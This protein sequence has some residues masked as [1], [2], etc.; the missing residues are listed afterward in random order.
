MS[1]TLRDL[2]LDAARDEP[3]HLHEI[4]AIVL[5]TRPEATEHGI[6]ARIYELLRGPAPRMMRVDES[7]YVAVDGPAWMVMLVGDAWTKLRELPNECANLLLTDAPYRMGTEKHVNTG[8]T[9]PHAR[10]QGRTYQTRDLDAAWF[11]EAFRVIK[12]NHAWRKMNGGTKTSGG[13]LILFAPA[14]TETTWPHLRALIDLAESCGFAYQGRVTWVHDRGMGYKVGGIQA[15]PILVFNKGRRDGL[16]HDTKFTNVITAK[17]KRN[18][19]KPGA[20]RHEAE[21]PPEVFHRL[22]EATTRPGDT[23]LDPF[24]GAASWARAT[25][26]SGRN[27]IL[28]D[29]DPR[30][31]AAIATAGGAA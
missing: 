26:E 10:M 9:R 13:A 16:L 17:R 8:T 1:A 30:W 18:P 25:L 14:E 11:R 23:V 28:I 29:L 2:V 19:C 24:A 31:P 4:L 6:R 15:E 3:R 27:V 12:S 20:D 7:V 21:K 22:I 5:S